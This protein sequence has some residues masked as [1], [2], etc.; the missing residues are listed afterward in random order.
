MTKNIKAIS[1]EMIE[2]YSKEFNKKKENRIIRNSVIK[3]GIEAA[4]VN[5]DAVIAM[6]PIFSDE[7]DTGKV[8]DQKSSGRCWMFAALN[9]FR[10]LMNKELNTKDLEL[11]QNYTM[12]WDKFEK[13]NFFF[14]SIIKTFNQDLDSR[15]VSWLLATPQQDGG[16]WDMLAGLIEK[17]GVV[18]KDAMPET[19]HSSNSS[20]MNS[21]LNLKLRQCAVKLRKLNEEGTELSKIK[22]AKEHMLKEI[23]NILSFCLGEPPKEFDFTYRDKDD[24]FHIDEKL[25]P[26]KFFKKYIHLDLNDY[27]SVINAPTKDK[28]FNKTYTVQ[29]L[30]SVIEGRP[31]KYLNVDI[32]TFRKLA[33][34]QI[35][36]GETVWF[37]CDV[38]KFAEKAKGILDTKVYDY[39]LAL[40]TDFKMTKAERL[41]YLG[42]ALT[43]AMVLTG[44]NIKDGKVNKWKVENSWGESR[45]TKGYFVMSDDWF[46]EYTYQIVVNKKYLSENLKKAYEQ[47]PVELKPWDPMGALA[48]INE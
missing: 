7:I 12:F 43:H 40:G 33:V 39:E 23:Y 26:K 21:M 17:Y 9:T 25:T 15:V 19:F 11:S 47:S 36:D 16:Q 48:V 18:P 27:V 29:F 6:N 31:I 4:A 45:G 32:E 37:G 44:V 10:H 28:P 13:A 22:T 46:A 8:T 3:N 20:A 14:E 38:G 30:G 2:S 42:S 5:N 24:K 1:F 35:K 41:D 34:D